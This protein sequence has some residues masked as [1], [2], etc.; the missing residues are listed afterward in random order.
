VNDSYTAANSKIRTDICED[1]SNVPWT[2]VT[3]K[4]NGLKARANVIGTIIK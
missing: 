1:E 2:T 4:K 3:R